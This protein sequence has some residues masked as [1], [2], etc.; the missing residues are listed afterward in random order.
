MKEL[1][2]NGQEI[3]QNIKA[4][5]E[6]YNNLLDSSGK[7]KDASLERSVKKLTNFI[8][9]NEKTL[10]EIGI[11]VTASKKLSID[12][13]DLLEC[14]P[15]KIGRV[16]S[17]SNTISS[18]LVNF[19]KKLARMAKPL[20]QDEARIRNQR[21]QESLLDLPVTTSTMNSTKIDFMA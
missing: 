14:T 7:I 15:K 1:K 17:N 9:D 11:K 20:I 8:K 16:F 10:E 12:K 3:Y 21:E 2:D 18:S 19:S 6:T 4:F 13:V 5:A